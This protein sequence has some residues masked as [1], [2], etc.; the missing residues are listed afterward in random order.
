MFFYFTAV[1]LVEAGAA[2][3]KYDYIFIAEG[4]ETDFSHSIGK[5]T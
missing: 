5:P 2:A 1:T 4:M 3:V